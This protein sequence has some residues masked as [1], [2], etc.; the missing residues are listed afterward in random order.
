MKLIITTLFVLFLLFIFSGCNFDSGRPF[1]TV[2][3]NK[4]VEMSDPFHP[5]LSRGEIESLLD[6][7]FPESATTIESFYEGGMDPFV[8]VRF[9]MEP[10]ELASFLTTND[11]GTELRE[12]DDF[13]A[14]RFEQREGLFGIEGWPHIGEWLEIV[15]TEPDRLKLIEK[16]DSGGSK[17]ELMVDQGNA[18]QIVLYLMVFMR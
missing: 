11:F 2:T 4:G 17:F 1:S 12:A 15:E 16:Q 13:A 8:A 18:D 7:Q 9:T 3:P 6:F 10:S 14:V 5:D